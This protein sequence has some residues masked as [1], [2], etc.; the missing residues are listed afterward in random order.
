MEPIGANLALE[1]MREIAHSALP[2]APVVPDPPPRAPRLR[3][4]VA[5]F[6]RGSARRRSRLADRLDPICAGAREYATG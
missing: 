6:L 5:A 1:A 3:G 2:D 4:A